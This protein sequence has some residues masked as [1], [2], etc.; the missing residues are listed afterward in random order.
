M[1]GCS[2]EKTG[3]EVLFLLV[4]F[5]LSA[6]FSRNDLLCNSKDQSSSVI[7]SAY[8]KVVVTQQQKYSLLNFLASKSLT[9]VFA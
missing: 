5:M 1:Q 3:R 7:Y 9:G 2:P 4:V 8:L 6:F